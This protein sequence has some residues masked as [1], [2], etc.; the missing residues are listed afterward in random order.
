MSYEVNGTLHHIGE[1]KQISETFSTRTFTIKT[2]DEYPQFISFELH[3][4]R[5]DLIEV[6]NLGDEVNVLL[7]L[8]GENGKI[9]FLIH[10]KHGESRK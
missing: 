4:D 6:Y 9:N 8:E 5:T 7:T 1:T 10:C 3:K 2:A